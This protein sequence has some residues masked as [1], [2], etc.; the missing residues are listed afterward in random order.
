MNLTEF[1]NKAFFPVFFTLLYVIIYL[2]R[3][4]ISKLVKNENIKILASNF[5]LKI[6]NFW[7]TIILPAMIALALDIIILLIF[8][9]PMLPYS[10]PLWFLLII[11]SLLNPISEEVVIRGFIFGCFLLTVL[12]LIEHAL[13]KPFPPFFH[14]IWILLMLLLQAFIFATSHENPT[15]FNWTLRLSSGILYGSLYLIYKRNL[16]PPITAHITHNLIITLGSL[17]L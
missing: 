4:R 15:L 16:L 7:M 3:K 8:R 6:N 5:K 12:P 13:R 10:E 9:K 11:R 14:K 2:F 17:K 1:I